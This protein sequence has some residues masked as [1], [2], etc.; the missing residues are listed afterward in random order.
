MSGIATVSIYCPPMSIDKISRKLRRTAVEPMVVTVVMPD[1]S[2]LTF[3]DVTIPP[4]D[5][6]AVSWP[7]YWMV[8]ACMAENGDD[9]SN[10]F[11]VEL[12]EEPVT[13]YPS[14]GYSLAHE[15][16][17]KFTLMTARGPVYGGTGKFPECKV[18]FFGKAQ[19]VTATG[20]ITIP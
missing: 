12:D 16:P 14:K 8:K 5:V 15:V 1:G 19:S 11:V 9:F 3:K 20:T 4:T 6:N 7:F 13:V 2:V 10:Y 17:C 18:P